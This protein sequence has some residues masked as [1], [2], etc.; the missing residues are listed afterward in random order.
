MGVQVVLARC[1]RMSSLN[2]I[3]RCSNCVNCCRFVCV[4]QALPS[5]TITA[6]VPTY[7]FSLSLVL[8]FDAIV[9]ATEDYKRHK[10]VEVNGLEYPYAYKVSSFVPITS[11]MMTFPT[12]NCITCG[13]RVH[14]YKCLARVLLLVTF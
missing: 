12:R 7:A 9:T 13:G 5:V 6:G 8:L 1:M 3:M 14:S 2:N 4:L 11:G 10:C